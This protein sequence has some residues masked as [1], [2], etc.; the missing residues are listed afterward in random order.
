MPRA[1]V[2]GASRG[3]GQAF[4][5][6]LTQRGYE[7]FATMRNPIDNPVSAATPV[8][9]DLTDEDSI[10]AAAATI[11]ARCDGVDL[12]LNVSGVLHGEGFGPEKRIEH[13]DPD[14]MRR[15]FEVNAFG[16]ALV[17]K[18]FFGLLTHDRPAV[19]ANVSARVGSIGDNH[20]GGW[21]SYRASKAAQ[22]QLTRTLAIEASRRSR[23]LTVVAI[24]PGTVDTDLSA[25][26]QR[27][28]PEGKLFSPRRAA[29]QLLD[30]LDGLGPDDNGGFFAWDGQPIPW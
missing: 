1:V 19:L 29:R 23:N 4:T 18:H 27:N 30:V 28:V 14:A 9:L 21:Y 5:E 10:A 17:A 24:H 26:F 7:V 16:P 13:L 2:Q 6:L 22:N 25:P 3:L 8:A 15:V 11:G 12:L 20:L